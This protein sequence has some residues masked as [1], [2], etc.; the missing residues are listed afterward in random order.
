MG[1]PENIV[2][3]LPRLSVSELKVVKQNCSVLV[4][5]REGKV[6]RENADLFYE[7]LIE[8][9][10]DELNLKLPPLNAIPSNS[11]KL[12]IQRFID[13]DEFCMDVFTLSHYDKKI[14]LYHT[15]A[16]LI[17]NSLRDERTRINTKTLIDRLQHTPN[18]FD[19]AFPGYV[20]SR[21]ADFIIKSKP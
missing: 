5:Q 7:V 6:A 10:K 20:Q 1:L 19:N 11:R 16:N 17:V 18:L 15:L 12:Y 8:V 3:A 21:I 9:T 13:V 14:A 2:K 4:E